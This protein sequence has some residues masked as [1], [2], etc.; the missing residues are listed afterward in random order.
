MKGLQRFTQ[1]LCLCATVALIDNPR[2]LSCFTSSTARRL[3]FSATVRCGC[4]AQPVTKLVLPPGEVSKQKTT[5][6]LLSELLVSSGAWNEHWKGELWLSE[7]TC[8]VKWKFLSL[9]MVPSVDVIGWCRAMSGVVTVYKYHT[10][11]VPPLSFLVL[12]YSRQCSNLLPSNIYTFL[13]QC[14]FHILHCL[15]CAIYL[16]SSLKH[17]VFLSKAHRRRSIFL[18]F[19]FP[20]WGVYLI[21]C[22][23]AQHTSDTHAAE[24]E[25][26]TH[27]QKAYEWWNNVKWESV[28]V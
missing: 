19:S 22:S 5:L 10:V 24:E 7:I 18:N 15:P 26:R 4:D 25:R 3:P 20:V 14:L 27:T 9:L 2:A 8:T 28:C 16:R 11:G 1:L 17:S 6:W 21:P 12:T 13:I 23:R